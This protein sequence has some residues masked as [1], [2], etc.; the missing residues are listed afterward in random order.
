MDVQLSDNI[1]KLPKITLTDTKKLAR[2]SAK[3]LLYSLD[4]TSFHEPVKQE[5]QENKDPKLS[6]SLAQ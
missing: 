6:V 5:K 2:A 1:I 3:S 4:L